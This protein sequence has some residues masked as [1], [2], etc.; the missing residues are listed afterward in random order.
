VRQVDRPG[1]PG[2]YRNDQNNLEQ[3][4]TG[5]ST[6]SDWPWNSYAFGEDFPVFLLITAVSGIRNGKTFFTENDAFSCWL[7]AIVARNENK[8]GSFLSTMLCSTGCDKRPH[9][10]SF[11]P[12]PQDAGFGAF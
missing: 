11:H 10:C 4:G 3:I 6:A 5:K 9:S 8:A 12:G 1:E 2:K 7:S